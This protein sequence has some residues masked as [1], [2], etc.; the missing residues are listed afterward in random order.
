MQF[1]FN[2]NFTYKSFDLT[3]FFNGNLGN[4]I[5]NY[6]RLKHTDPNGGG[7]YFRSMLDYAKLALIDPTGLNTDPNNVYVVNDNTAIPAIRI[8]GNPETNTA[9]ASRFIEDGSYIRL[10]NVN[11]GYKL[12]QSCFPSL[13]L[14]L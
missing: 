13:K 8:S 4:K 11:M 5:L 7:N 12:P 2:N 14:I 9:V 1:G 10:K 6:E 3:L